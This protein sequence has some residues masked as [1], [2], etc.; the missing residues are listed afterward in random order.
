MIKIIGDQLKKLYDDHF[1]MLLL[2]FLFIGIVVLT[3]HLMHK[4]DAGGDDSGFIVWSETQAA[5]ILGTLLG[6][7]KD[8]K[9]PVSPTE[10]NKEVE[11]QP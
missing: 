5:F 3:V 9:P 7:M 8:Q 10:E 1:R 2:A 6:M 11:K 4:S